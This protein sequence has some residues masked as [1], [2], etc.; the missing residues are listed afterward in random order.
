MPCDCVGRAG[1]LGNRRAADQRLQ[2]DAF[3]RSP[4]HAW[5][6]HDTSNGVSPGAPVLR[7]QVDRE[8]VVDPHEH[9][10][11]KRRRAESEN[12]VGEQD[13]QRTAAAAEDPL[14]SSIDLTARGEEAQRELEGM[15][16][17]GSELDKF[18]RLRSYVLHMQE[19][20]SLLLWKED[21]L[22]LCWFWLDK[23]CLSLNWEVDE[24]S[25]TPRLQSD[26]SDAE[27]GA[28]VLGRRHKEGGSLLLERIVDIVPLG[29][30]ADQLTDSPTDSSFSVQLQDTRLDIVA[31]TSLDFQVWYFGLAFATRLR[32]NALQESDADY[33]VTDPQPSEDDEA[34][35]S[36]TGAA[37]PCA[38]T[39]TPVSPRAYVNTRLS[40][41]AA[42]TEDDPD[43]FHHAQGSQ[44]AGGGGDEKWKRWKAKDKEQRRLIER[45]LRE[46]QTLKEVRRNKDQAIQRL[47][48]DLHLAEARAAQDA[49]FILEAKTPATSMESD[50]N[51]QH[52]EQYRTNAR[53][54]KLLEILQV[55]KESIEQ[56]WAL[57]RQCLA[58]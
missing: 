28:G 25:I 2:S 45:L 33:S 46:N 24:N 32:L 22:E 11:A 1:E 43:T 14:D 17:E 55:K 13:S 10:H 37:R 40:S 4:Q 50:K 48:H 19:G 18:I 57:L 42:D 7:E 49:A 35:P 9:S 47:L 3:S 38:H 56:L 36:Q 58:E 26:D 29:A 8:D 31:P 53:N 20:A 16:T 39:P 41:G 6:L 54:R 44:R 23:D 21:G 5:A 27:D 30:G 34:S 15:G 51:W 52:R 12:A